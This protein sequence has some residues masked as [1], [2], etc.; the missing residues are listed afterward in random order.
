MEILKKAELV[1]ENH[2]MEMVEALHVLDIQVIEVKE[3]YVDFNFS[4]VYNSSPM[5][6]QGVTYNQDVFKHGNKEIGRA[7]E[8][9]RIWGKPAVIMESV[10]TRSD[11]FGRNMLSPL[12]FLVYDRGKHNY[13]TA[14]YYMAQK[15]HSD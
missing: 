6:V 5:T 3:I 7:M 13:I 14:G 2:N 15:L 9:S 1:I 4:D 8:Y 12:L 10:F 11:D